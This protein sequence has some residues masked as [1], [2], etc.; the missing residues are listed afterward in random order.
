MLGSGNGVVDVVK[1][2]LIAPSPLVVIKLSGLADTGSTVSTISE[3]FFKQNFQ[4]KLKSC[5]WLELRAA[6]GLEI[7]YLGVG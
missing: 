2:R 1:E 3:S 7:L 6:K 4:E 5:H